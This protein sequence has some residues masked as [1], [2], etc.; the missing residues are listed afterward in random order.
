MIEPIKWLKSLLDV[1]TA[2]TVKAFLY[3][4]LGGIVENSAS[5]RTHAADEKKIRGGGDLG[6]CKLSSKE[7]CIPKKSELGKHKKSICQQHN[8]LNE[9]VFQ[10]NRFFL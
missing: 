8:S 10:D 3:G 2:A 7:K 6:R 9:S 1:W 4:T 5:Q